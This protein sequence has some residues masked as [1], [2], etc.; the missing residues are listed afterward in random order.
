MNRK[1]RLFLLLSTVLLS[2]FPLLVGCS[3]PKAPTLTPES[4]EITSVTPTG[5]GVRVTLSA[6]NPNDF[7]LNTRNVK[8][9]ITLGNKVTLGPMEKPHGVGLPANKA[10]SVSVEFQATWEQAAQLAQLATSGPTVP[11]VVEGTITVGGKSLNV[12]LP[13]TIKGE[14]SQTQLI[15][16]GL[17]G[18]PSIPGLPVF[19]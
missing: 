9:T 8:G 4:T 11:Y 16:A 3:K 7:A 10:T 15:A 14:V 6:H 18:L 19:K 2:M 1:A 13:F 12:D 5:I 17:K